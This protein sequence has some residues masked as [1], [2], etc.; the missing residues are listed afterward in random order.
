MAREPAFTEQQKALIRELQEDILLKS[1]PFAEIGRRIGYSEEQ[2][3]SQ[4]KVWKQEGLIRRFGSVLR[5]YRAGIATNV[6][7]VWN[8]PVE[9]MAKIGPV[10]ASFS[11][12]S[13]CYQRPVLPQWPYN[14]YAM[15]HARSTDECKRIAEKIAHQTGI[16]DYQLLFSTREYKKTSMKYFDA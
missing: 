14:L 5:H 8:V 12:V 1:A 9:R 7:I 11:E 2:V 3:I 13:H 16:N 6:M 4:I 10:V 15:V